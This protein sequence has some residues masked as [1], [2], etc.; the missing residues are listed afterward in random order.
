MSVTL[1][2]TLTMRHISHPAFKPW[3]LLADALFAAAAEISRAQKSRRKKAGAGMRPVTDTPLWNVVI[4]E[5]KKNLRRYGAK[6]D[7]AR[8]L[9]IP[10]QRLNDFLQAR[11]RL[12]NAEIALRLTSW[13]CEQ[14][15]QSKP[16]EKV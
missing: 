2:V 15:T 5:A 16:N 4:A 6:A 3:S 13:I 1:L 8:H 11:T 7:L 9:G 12:P 10:R 14:H